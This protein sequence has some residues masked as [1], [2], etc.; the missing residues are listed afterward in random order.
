MHKASSQPAVRLN[1]TQHYMSIIVIRPENIC[2][3]L[4][5]DTALK[6]L[7]HNG[8]NFFKAILK[9]YLGP[10]ILGVLCRPFFVCVRAERWL[11]LATALCVQPSE[12]V[13]K[14]DPWETFQL[15][16]IRLRFHLNFLWWYEWLIFMLSDTQSLLHASY[17]PL[18]IW[19]VWLRSW[20]FNF[21]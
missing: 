13:K 12:P 11:L 10:R 1:L 3:C 9:F 7:Y 20:I 15:C 4:Y 2:I 21:I 5:K 8:V 6:I 14:Y 16:W 19:P 17:W 18:K